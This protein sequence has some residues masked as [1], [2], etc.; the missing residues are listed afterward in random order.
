MNV[1]PWYQSPSTW[2]AIATIIAVVYESGLIPSDNPAYKILGLAVAALTALG[3]I[4]KRGLVE[5]AA[6]KSAAISSVATEAVKANPPPPQ[7]KP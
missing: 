3:L 5:A 6:I 1:K 4:A 2:V 7:P